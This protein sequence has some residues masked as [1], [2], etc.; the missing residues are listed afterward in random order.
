MN[1]ASLRIEPMA[2]RALKL[3][4][5]IWLS[6]PGRNPPVAGSVRM[7]CSLSIVADCSF[8]PTNLSTADMSRRGLLVKSCEPLLRPV[9]TTAAMSLVPKLRSKKRRIAAFTRG[10]R[11]NSVCRSSST[12]R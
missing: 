7:F 10:V 8:R 4:S 5:I 11:V 6:S 1:S 9:N 2:L 3:R 12:I